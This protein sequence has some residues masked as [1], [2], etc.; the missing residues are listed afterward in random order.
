MP[1]NIAFWYLMQALDTKLNS[2]TF[3]LPN[4]SQSQK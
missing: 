4:S 2:A 1:F 3:F